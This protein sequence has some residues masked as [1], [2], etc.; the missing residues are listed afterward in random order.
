MGAIHRVGADRFSGVSSLVRGE[1]LSALA[2]AGGMLPQPRAAPPVG[3]TPRRPRQPLGALGKRLIRELPCAFVGCQCK[4]FLIRALEQPPRV[5]GNPLPAVPGWSHPPA[6]AAPAPLPS[7]APPGNPSCIPRPGCSRAVPPPADVGLVGSPVGPCARWD[8]GRSRW[9]T[10]AAARRD[11]LPLQTISG[12][13]LEQNSDLNCTN[14]TNCTPN[15]S[16]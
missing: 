10:R 12:K 14:A 15:Y 1:P 4:S 13:G 3:C 11:A 5:H 8:D 6:A 7:A 2:A 16:Y 9:M